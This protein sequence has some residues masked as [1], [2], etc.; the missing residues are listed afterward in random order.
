MS[1]AL[2]A[3][4][5]TS[6]AGPTLLSTHFQSDQHKIYQRGNGTIK[7]WNAKQSTKATQIIVD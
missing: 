7:P 2:A 4:F 3:M 5:G 1:V 6:Q